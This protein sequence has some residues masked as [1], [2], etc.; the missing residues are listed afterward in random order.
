MGERTNNIITKEFTY[1]VPD[2][3][4]AQTNENADTASWTYEGP[5][6]LY[7]FAEQDT[8]IVHISP[9]YTI[10]DDG[11][12]IPTPV[13]MYKIEVDATKTNH[14]PLA[15]IIYQTII[16]TELPTRSETLPDGSICNIL[17]PIPPHEAYDDDAITY[18]ASNNEFNYPWKSPHTSWENLTSMRNHLLNQS[19]EW[20]KDA[21][22][23][24]EDQLLELKAYRQL[25]RN[26]PTTFS[27][28]DPWKVPF[29]DV[30]EFLT[31]PLI[32]E[33]GE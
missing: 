11:D 22:E 24:T 30:P 19:D 33:E 20:I 5:D 10:A 9:S 23:Y 12:D 14:L 1:N 16:F 32:I 29:P 3:Y 27:G 26:L 31:V 2:D 13:G 4:L 15:S 8:N 18:N 28:I 21:A 17:D 25:L 7:I 6:R